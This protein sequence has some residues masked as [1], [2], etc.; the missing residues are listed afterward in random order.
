MQTG[1]EASFTANGVH[2]PTTFSETLH[3]QYPVSRGPEDRRASD[4]RLHV[5]MVSEKQV[6][7]L[8]TL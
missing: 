5:Q 8:S 1:L 6:K 7:H 4:R 3:I 2:N